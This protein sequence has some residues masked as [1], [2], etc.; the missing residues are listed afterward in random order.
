L[1]RYQNDYT[2]FDLTYKS[3]V[4]GNGGGGF[5]IIVYVG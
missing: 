3:G 5:V 2:A 4:G 1:A